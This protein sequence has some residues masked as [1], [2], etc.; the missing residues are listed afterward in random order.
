MPYDLGIS[1]VIGGSYTP[2][3][4]LNTPA[5]AQAQFLRRTPLGP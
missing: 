3:S 1:K 5:Y 2:E 4:T